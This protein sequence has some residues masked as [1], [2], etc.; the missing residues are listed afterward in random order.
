MAQGTK[1]NAPRVGGRPIT[2]TTSGGISGAAQGAAA[3]AVVGSVVPVVG[4]AVGAVVGAIVGGV[5]GLMGGAEA[6]KSAYYKKVA[7]K[8]AKMGQERQ[9]A[10]ERNNYIREF[11]ARR[12]MTMMGYGE[13]GASRSSAVQGAADSLGAQFAFGQAYSEGQHFIQRQYSKNMNKAGKA[14]QAAQTIFATQGAVLQA[15]STFG[16]LYSGPATAAPTGAPAGGI[17]TSP[18]TTPGQ[19]YSPNF[20]G[21]RY[22]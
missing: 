4:T 13:D 21:P 14:A 5:S 10:L 1:I 15:A 6:D 22:A 18:L 2:G 17:P 11:R 8:W 12:A 9:A 7:Y 3:G 16:S 20:T 19:S